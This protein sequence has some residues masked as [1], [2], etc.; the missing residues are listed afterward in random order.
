M[1]T[2]TRRRV[3]KHSAESLRRKS[4]L[5]A[6]GHTYEVLAERAGVSWR[7]VKF[8]MDDVKTSA[9]IARAFDGLVRE[10]AS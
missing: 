8:W 7:M 10:K 5:K 9:P 1:N 3:K 2:R 6:S 4:V